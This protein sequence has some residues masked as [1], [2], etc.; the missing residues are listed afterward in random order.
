MKSAAPH[1]R[2][3]AAA[4]SPVWERL[5]AKTQGVVTP[6]NILTLTGGVV[7]LSGLWMLSAQQFGAAFWAIGIGRV[8][9]VLDGHVARLTRTASPIGEV[10]DAG[11]D[12]VVI[13]VAGVILALEHTAPLAVLLVIITLQI[14]VAVL[15]TAARLGHIQLHSSR[16]GK[17]STFALWLALLLYILT[18]WLYSL[19]HIEQ[20]RLVYVAANWL[21][22]GVVA[23]I[24]AALIGYLSVALKQLRHKDRG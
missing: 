6:G 15:A 20:G 9:D 12:K 22:A 21:M 17:Y 1:D 18:D 24:I 23:G 16:V 13:L 7:T 5:A 3:E 2:Q 10:L 19:H 11:M 14:I 4:S 8:C